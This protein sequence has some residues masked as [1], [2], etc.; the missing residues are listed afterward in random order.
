MVLEIGFAS[1]LDL[2]LDGSS[3]PYPVIGFLFLGANMLCDGRYIKL[4]K[5]DVLNINIF[6]YKT[7]II[8]LY[9]IIILLLLIKNNTLFYYL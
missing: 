6:L 5:V 3:R 8:K 1:R 4:R 2:G 9:E 7:N